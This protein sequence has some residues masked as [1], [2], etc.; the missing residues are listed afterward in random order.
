MRRA[1]P[2]LARVVGTPV[3]TGVGAHVSALRALRV[4]DH[5]AGS[6]ELD[7]LDG[8]DHLQ[9]QRELGAWGWHGRRFG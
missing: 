8:L 2:G 7:H 4:L 1:R 5:P 3:V 6:L 9:V